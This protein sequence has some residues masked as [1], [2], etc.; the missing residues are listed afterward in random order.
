MKR[1]I[2]ICGALALIFMLAL[3]AYAQND[4]RLDGQVMDKDGNPWVGVTIKVTNPETGQ[5]YTL[6][7]DKSGKFIQ[8]GL[9]GGVYTV[10]VVS[11]KDNINYT[12]KTLVK[13]GE[14]NNWVCNFKELIAKSEVANPDAEKKKEEAENNF[15]AMKEHFTNG[16]NA[17]ND[18]APLKTQ[19]ATATADQKTAIAQKLSADYA[20]AVTEFQQ[21]EKAAG[22]KE[23]KNHA[24][25]WAHLGDAYEGAG[26]YGDAANAFA[27]AITLQP[28]P[29]YYARESTNLA[30]DGTE[31]TDPKV[32]EQKLADAAADCDKA[33]AADPTLAAMCWKNIGIVLSNKGMLAQAVTPMQKATQA[34]PRDAQSWY[35]LGGALSGT[36]STKQEGDKMTYIVPPGTV[37]AYQKCVGAAPTGPYAQLCKEA[38]DGIAQLAGGESTEIGKKPKKK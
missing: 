11:E 36:I 22:E 14:E 3:A 24:L 34:D 2:P 29:Q 38:G 12:E 8:L 16:L 26:R 5:T 27:Q 28:Q 33:V 17:M 6:K 7:T 9:A 23:V 4:S 30:H 15:K 18:A 31:A 20:T 25:I 35:L 37:E 13:Q 32:Q 10:T 21:A 1:L 19:L